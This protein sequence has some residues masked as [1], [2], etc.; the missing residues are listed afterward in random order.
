MNFF[1]LLSIENFEQIINCLVT[2]YNHLIDR[3]LDT[4]LGQHISCFVGLQ[5]LIS[6]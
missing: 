3:S 5:E 2:I 1:W 6:V 4:Y